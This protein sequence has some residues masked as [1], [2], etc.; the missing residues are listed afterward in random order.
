MELGSSAV[1]KSE[2]F[3][4]EIRDRLSIDRNLACTR[5]DCLVT[6]TVDLVYIG[7]AVLQFREDEKSS[8]VERGGCTWKGVRQNL[9]PELP[10]S[11]P[12]ASKGAL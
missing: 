1:E 9:H 12:T 10:G 11:R 6:R 7:F 8:R 4:D 3:A 2:A 5:M